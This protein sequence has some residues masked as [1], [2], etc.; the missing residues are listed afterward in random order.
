M[1]DHTQDAPLAGFNGGRYAQG[2]AG[3]APMWMR[4]P[5]IDVNVVG[6][7]P[8][9]PDPGVEAGNPTGLLDDATG[10]PIFSLLDDAGDVIHLYYHDPITGAKTV[11]TTGFSPT[12]ST[13]TDKDVAYETLAS[14]VVERIKVYTPV[15]DGVPGTPT[16]TKFSDGTPYTPVAV[17]EISPKPQKVQMGTEDIAITGAGVAL[18]AVPT[19]ANSD[20]DNFPSSAL[21]HVHVDSS[22]NA[23]GI[24]YTT[25][26]TNPSEAK[27]F[28]RSE[29]QP[30]VL[31]TH[32]EIINFRAAPLDGAGD[33]APGESIQISVE[34]N[35]IG[36]DKDDV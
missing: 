9:L 12:T 24:A 10:M 14:G 7:N 27:E 26:G 13:S 33:L 30:I 19:A 8:P 11:T 28:E 35:N 2:P 5:S 36:A 32:E 18:A 23:A 1:V 29:G 34:Y 22:D 31:D 17:A 6:P 15:V 4:H 25:D 16:Y 3:L 21:V 20:G